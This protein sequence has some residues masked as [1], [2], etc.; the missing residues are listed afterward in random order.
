MEPSSFP[1]EVNTKSSFLHGV[2]QARLSTVNC[3]KGTVPILR[4]SS[5][6]DIITLHSNYQV[7]HKHMQQEVSF[8]Y[9][10]LELYI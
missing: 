10:L 2:A 3:P 1:I 8:L 5:K 9:L 7:G 6:L 4:T